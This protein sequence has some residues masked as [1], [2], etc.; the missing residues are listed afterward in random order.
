MAELTR[1][2]VNPER[3]LGNQRAQGLWAIVAA[4]T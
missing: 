2:L 1:Q 3:L 4:C